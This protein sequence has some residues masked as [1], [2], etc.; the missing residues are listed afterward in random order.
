MR[1]PG[2][3]R[4]LIRSLSAV[5]ALAVA[6]AGSGCSMVRIGYSQLDTIAAWKADEYFDLDPQQKDLFTARFNRLHDW[7][8]QHQLPDYAAFLDEV[9]LRFSR[10][11]QRDDVLW[12]IEGVKA[13][14]RTIVERGADDAAALLLTV[15]PSQLSAV[16]S[17]W[18]KDNIRYVRDYA[19]EGD[20]EDQRRAR[21]RRTVDRIRHWTGSLSQEQEARIA[22]MIAAMPDIAQLRHEDRKRRQREFLALMNHRADQ[23]QFA[24]RLRGWLLHWEA[25]RDP[26]YERAYRQSLDMGVQ[27]ILSVDRMLTPQ[28]RANAMDRLRSYADDFRSLSQRRGLQAAT[29]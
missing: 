22:A 7:H 3:C 23:S 19:L 21:L 17:Q 20:Q 1:A 9:R 11:L 8:R 10:G 28:Q 6:V 27:M 29:H 16:R 12:T 5:L 4:N 26:E 2:L 25:G 18:D 24:R 14:Y 15:T 13:R